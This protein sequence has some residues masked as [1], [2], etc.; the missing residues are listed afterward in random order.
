ME[1]SQYV[2]TCTMVFIPIVESSTCYDDCGASGCG[3]GCGGGW[4]E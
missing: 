1:R 4:N 3:G 2:T